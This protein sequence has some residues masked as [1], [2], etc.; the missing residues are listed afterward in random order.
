MLHLTQE[1][2]KDMGVLEQVLSRRMVE[3]LVNAIGVPKQKELSTSF[4]G[5]NH[6]EHLIIRHGITEI[7]QQCLSKFSVDEFR[8]FP[9]SPRETQRRQQRNPDSNQ[10]DIEMA[11]WAIESEE[12]LTQGQEDRV[13][14][15]E[16]LEILLTQQQMQWGLRNQSILLEIITPQQRPVRKKTTMGQTLASQASLHA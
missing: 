5:Y 2:G 10:L 16:V 8:G 7:K 4:S 14:E 15:L 11:K 13:V 3:F 12:S 1:L 9:Q 6:V